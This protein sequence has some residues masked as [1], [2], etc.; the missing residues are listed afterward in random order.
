MAF[1]GAIALT[2]MPTPATAESPTPGV[3]P[4]FDLQ[5]GQ[6]ISKTFNTPLIGSAEVR[7]TGGDDCRNNP[8]FK[9]TCGG[10]RIKLHRA[11]G[12][13][14]RIST[15]WLSQ[16][17]AGTSVPDIDTY[18]FYSPTGS[19]T[20]AQVGG[21]SGAMPEQMKLT[22]PKQDEYDLVV[23]A[24]AGAVPGYTVVVEYLNSAGASPTPAKADI[25]L[26][27]GKQFKKVINSPLVGETGAPATFPLVSWA[28]DDCRNDPTKNLLCDV[29]RVK[30]NRDKSK[31]AINFLVIEL[32]WDA[33]YTPD[34]AVVA[35]GLSGIQE[36]N[37]DIMLWDTATH[38]LDREVV[39]GEDSGM[40]ERAAVSA[41]Q[42]EYDIVVQLSNGANTQ[43]TLRAYLSNE[44]FDKPFESLDQLDKPADQSGSDDGTGS[45]FFGGFNDGSVDPDLPALDLAPINPD[46]DIA[47]IGLGVNEQFDSKQLSLGGAAR[48]TAVTRK[49]PSGFVLVLALAVLPL[50]AGVGVVGALRRRRHALI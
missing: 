31:D 49:A 39:G 13:Y 19:F 20:N 40:P 28:P 30:L 48:N 42:D 7:P 2:A 25:V 22:D 17:A 44:V 18:L 15:S 43:Y 33:V 12:Y 10:H 5:P 3:K 9:L 26:S 1:S 21:T 34:L 47:G 24:Y 36:P 4:D 41:V 50:I 14:L 38:Q 6:S 11:P 8:V 16:S 23:G 27:P 45:G 37:L 29:Y 46:A 32:E 35:A